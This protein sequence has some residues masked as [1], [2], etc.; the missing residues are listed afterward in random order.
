MTLKDIA[1]KADVSQATVSRVLNNDST[2]S[3]T[4]ETRK[5]ILAAV[6]ELGYRTVRQRYPEKNG[7]NKSVKKIPDREGRAAEYRIGI[8][9]MFELEEQL[10]D[11]YY[12][13][14]KSALD[15]A[16]FSKKWTTAMLY[17][18]EQK[19]FVKH[20]NIPLDGII[21][22]G[23]FTLEEISD[24]EEYTDNIVFL[25]SS[26][27]EQ[28]YFSIVPNYHLAIREMLH[29]FAEAGRRK[30]AYLGSVYTF[31]DTKDL[32]MD[33]R[34]YYYKNSLINRGV[35]DEN[36]IIECEM[37]S[38]SSYKKTL[39]YLDAHQPDEY[40]D[41]VFVASDAA[42]PGVVKALNEKGIEIPGQMGVIT[43]NNT[44]FSEFSNPPL[45][46]VELFMRESVEAAVACMEAL[47][48]HTGVPLKI[49]VPCALIKRGSA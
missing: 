47:W 9:Q 31:G 39:D 44:S 8:A 32:S 2:L 25:D 12:F 26:P 20:D 3:V 16:C 29:R 49:T 36:L 15:E 17:R 43:F 37:N 24:F 11:I 35:Y 45:T 6:Q 34:F 48:R 30:V 33:P 4:E 46:S 7:K 14:L 1:K 13:K 23:R 10:E 40:P 18:N 19:R 21:A 22:I 41:A 42:A 27:N 38:R 5:K 28:K